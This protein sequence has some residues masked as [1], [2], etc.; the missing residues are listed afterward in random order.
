MCVR[1][2]GRSTLFSLDTQHTSPSPHALFS[3][4]HAAHHPSH[5]HTHSLSPATSAAPT[6]GASATRAAATL[7]NPPTISLG[8]GWAAKQVNAWA[9]VA[10]TGGSGVVAAEAVRVGRGALRAA[11]ARCTAGGGWRPAPAAR[12]G[13]GRM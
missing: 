12:R 2:A 4:K 9:W 11:G 8:V 3:L 13:G 6:G 1:D 7:A 5:T 10:G